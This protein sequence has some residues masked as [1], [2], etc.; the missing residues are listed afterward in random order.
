MSI[1]TKWWVLQYR[2]SD[3]WSVRS[4]PTIFWFPLF[5]YR[6]RTV[7]PFKTKEEAIVKENELNAKKYG[8]KAK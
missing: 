5:N 7:G 6:C 4:I 8:R 1:I 2:T 3:L